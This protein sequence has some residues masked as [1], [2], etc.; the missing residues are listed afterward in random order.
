MLL[1]NTYNLT[2]EAAVALRVASDKVAFYACRF[3]GIQD[4]V[5]DVSGRHYYSNCYFEGATDFICGNGKS[6]FEVKK[7]LHIANDI[8]HVNR[9]DTL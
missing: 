3:I 1:Q 4:T 5:H 7:K 2:R 8:F 6:L 9:T